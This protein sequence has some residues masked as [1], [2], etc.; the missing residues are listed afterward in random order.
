MKIKIGLKGKRF[1]N[2]LKF[3]NPVP[4]KNKLGKFFKIKREKTARKKFSFKGPTRDRFKPMKVVVMSKRTAAFALI[5]VIF[6]VGLVYGYRESL[7]AATRY[8]M[9]VMAQTNKLT[10]IYR[11]QTEEKKL[12]ISFDA[13]WGADKTGEILSILKENGD[14][15]TTF[16]LTGFWLEKYP[17]LVKK[18]AE[19]GH[20][21]G[22]HTFTHPHLN[23]LSEQ[24][25]KE[26][27]SKTHNLIHQ[28]TGQSPVL[29]RPPFGEYN[30]K[31][32]T[33]IE[34]MGY[35][36]IQWDVDSLDWKNVSAQNIVQRVTSQA[37]PGSIILFHNNGE[38]T[39]EVLKPILAK[40]K[41]DG[42]QV[43]PISQLIYQEK[44]YID[45]HTGEQKPEQ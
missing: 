22:N 20:E 17:E 1:I 14:L 38:H 39:A 40:F 2:W 28:L 41:D 6:I 24:Q 33:T 18:I 36:I 11:V 35:K 37:S 23:S 34:G 21:I 26:E 44:Y 31:V 29:F 16:F 3:F 25:I 5:G 7:S 9:E 8:V 4:I 12:A 43:V 15:K 13:C 32:I 27:I 45:R 42:Y 19:S 30:N 10:P